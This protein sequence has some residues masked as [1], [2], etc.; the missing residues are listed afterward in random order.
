LINLGE[1][2]VNGSVST[3]SRATTA[4]S[5][6]RNTVIAFFTF[7]FKNIVGREGGGRQK[8]VKIAE[9]F[10]GIDEEMFCDNMNRYSLLLISKGGVYNA[11]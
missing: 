9:E 11:F 8:L 6:Y 5:S 1:S 4:T 10:F 2:F 7:T 3:S